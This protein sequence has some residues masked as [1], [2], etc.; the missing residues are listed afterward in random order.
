MKARGW[1]ALILALACGGAIVVTSGGAARSGAAKTGAAKSG[2]AQRPPPVVV[3]RDGA[4][5]LSAEAR[6]DG[7]CLSI[8]TSNA[9]GPPL[10]GTVVVDAGEG[11]DRLL[12]GVAITAAAV[13]VEVRRA[14]KLLGS[15]ATVE[16]SAYKGTWPS[17]MRFAL[18]RIPKGT[19]TDG[20][21][22]RG[23]DARGTLVEVVASDPFSNGLVLDR[24][25]VLA[26]E[27]PAQR[28]GRS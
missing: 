7:L 16:A 6:E 17:A 12:A 25:R 1:V 27:A 5:R 13:R 4:T 28:G 23:Y 3:A 11:D 19:R 15:A 22:A 10:G 8:A 14:N 18:V 21:R 26:E 24:R 9:C 2:A 20:V